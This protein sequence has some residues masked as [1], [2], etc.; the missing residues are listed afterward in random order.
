M[1]KFTLQS[2]LFVMLINFFVLDNTSLLLIF[3]N[4]Y[5][6]IYKNSWPIIRCAYTT[7]IIIMKNV[8]ETLQVTPIAT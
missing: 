2:I 1:S 8:I 5:L 4:N 7:L 3:G 6:L